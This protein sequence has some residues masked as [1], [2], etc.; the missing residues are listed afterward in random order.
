MTSATD[1]LIKNR[2]SYISD[3]DRFMV[4]L[5]NMIGKDHGLNPKQVEKQRFTPEFQQF[6]IDYLKVK[7]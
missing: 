1:E 6:I 5:R 3:G 2:A 7:D 4:P